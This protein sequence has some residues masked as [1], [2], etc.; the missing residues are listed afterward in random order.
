MF[1]NRDSEA[2]EL[3]DQFLKTK[4]Y[5]TDPD[6]VNECE[7]EQLNVAATIYAKNKDYTR[8]ITTI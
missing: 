7:F 1:T 8:G 4:K 3:I 6:K 2:L 5:K